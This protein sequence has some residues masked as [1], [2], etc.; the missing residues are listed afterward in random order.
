MSNMIYLDF[1]RMC[2]MIYQKNTIGLVIMLNKI[3][4]LQAIRER[5][6][7]RRYCAVGYLKVMTL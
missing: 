5:K 6:T 2:Q 4:V 1:S 3:P 7:G